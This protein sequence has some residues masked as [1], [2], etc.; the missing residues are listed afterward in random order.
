MPELNLNELELQKVTDKNVEDWLSDE[1]HEV[2]SSGVA[3]CSLGN[4]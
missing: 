1:A 4:G 2:P 3:G